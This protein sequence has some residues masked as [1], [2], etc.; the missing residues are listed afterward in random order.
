MV[1]KQAGMTVYWD[2]TV[3]GSEV[4]FKEEFVPEDEGSYNVLVQKGKQIGRMTSNLFHVNEP[5]KILITFANPTSK[6]RK[7]FYRYKL[8]PI[9]PMNPLPI[10]D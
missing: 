3:T 8:K 10:T 9:A 1:T 2:F 6:N 4:T 7:I 5:G